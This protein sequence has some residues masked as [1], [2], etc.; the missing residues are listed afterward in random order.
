MAVIL[1]F[2]RFVS[3]TVISNGIGLDFSFSFTCS[4]LSVVTV[5]F[6]PETAIRELISNLQWSKLFLLVF[7]SQDVKKQIEILLVPNVFDGFLVWVNA[8]HFSHS[9]SALEVIIMS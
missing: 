8:L 1:V 6:V 5:G 9:S 3:V 4:C 7:F 2:M